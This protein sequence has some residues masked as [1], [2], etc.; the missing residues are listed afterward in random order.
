MLKLSRSLNLSGT[1]S[2]KPIPGHASFA[3]LPERAYTVVP[4]W[5]DELARPVKDTSFQYDRRHTDNSVE[6]AE[7]LLPFRHL[8]HLKLQRFCVANWESFHVLLQI[9]TTM[10]ALEEL[11]LSICPRGDGYDFLNEHALNIQDLRQQPKSPSHIK[12][13][14]LRIEYEFEKDIRD[15][16]NESLEASRLSEVLQSLEPAWDQVQLVRWMP[17]PQNPAY[18]LQTE[19]EYLLSF[20]AISVLEMAKDGFIKGMGL[21]LT[22]E[23]MKKIEEIRLYCDLDI[24]DKEWP[25][26]S[27]HI[28][29]P[30]F[31]RRMF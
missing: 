4:E 3:L 12:R 11:S 6:A 17:S 27:D 25:M 31:T 29:V 22:P 16:V 24:D 13:L 20:P 14:Y 19:Y 10:S 18:P 9:V 5:D 7:L 8:K 1:A 21:D 15:L 30:D 23:T 28:L 26:V 2:T